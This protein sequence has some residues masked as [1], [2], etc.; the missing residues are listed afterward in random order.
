MSGDGTKPHRARPCSRPGTCRGWERRAIASREAEMIYWRQQEA[1]GRNRGY[2]LTRRAPV[3]LTY[4]LQPRSYSKHAAW[5]NGRRCRFFIDLL[6][7]GCR[8]DT[9]PNSEYNE[10]LREKENSLFS[11]FAAEY[12]F[13]VSCGAGGQTFRESSSRERGPLAPNS[14][15]MCKRTEFLRLLR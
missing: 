5:S 14:K 13:A 10:C 1:P 12:R 8:W 11:P 7:S 15:L 3:R 4:L 2:S 9:T 6:E